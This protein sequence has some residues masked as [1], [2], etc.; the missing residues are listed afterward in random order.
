MSRKD[1]IYIVR[2][3]SLTILVGAEINRKLVCSFRVSE[4]KPSLDHFDLKLRYIL[5]FIH[6]KQLIIFY[7]HGVCS[8][9]CCFRVKEAIF[10]SYITLIII[11]IVLYLQDL[12]LF[13]ACS[14]NLVTLR[15]KSSY[16]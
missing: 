11:F 6:P 1:L 3:Y 10:C 8:I 2:I 14:S 16:L 7:L 5:H 12:L 13:S 15:T 9:S 4:F